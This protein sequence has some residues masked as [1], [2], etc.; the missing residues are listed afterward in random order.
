MDSQRPPKQIETQIQAI[1]PMEQMIHCRCNKDKIKIRLQCIDSSNRHY[2][3]KVCYA[4]SQLYS[5]RIKKLP[6]SVE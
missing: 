6:L 4:A 5:I 1:V 3:S 2:E